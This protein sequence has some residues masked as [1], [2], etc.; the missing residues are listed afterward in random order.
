MCVCVCVCV[1]LDEL[2]PFRRPFDTEKGGPPA[3]FK[4]GDEDYW[5]Q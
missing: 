4:C 3:S 5:A 1:V 2:V